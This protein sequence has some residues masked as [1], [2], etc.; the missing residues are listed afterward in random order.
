M[1]GGEVVVNAT[2]IGLNLLIEGINVL[3]FVDYPSVIIII[4]PTKMMRVGYN[5][6]YTRHKHK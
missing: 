3:T 5:H 2:L 1:T 4:V 6:L